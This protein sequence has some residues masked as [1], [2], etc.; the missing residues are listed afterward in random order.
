M[1][2]N[3]KA[4]LEIG[5]NTIVI[6][7]IAM[8]LLGLGIIFVKNLFG[9]I[10]PIT[11]KI[12]PPDLQTPPSASTPLIMDVQTFSLKT[13]DSYELDLGIYNADQ[14]DEAFSV[15]VGN[16]EVPPTATVQTQVPQ[17]RVLPQLIKSGEAGY[18]TTYIIAQYN[19]GG[20]A[21]KNME[22]GDFICNLEVRKYPDVTTAQNAK[23][24]GGTVVTSLQF[25]MTV[26]Q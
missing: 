13:G 21:L 26:D 3:K 11:Q 12:K 5:I 17:I 10:N 2:R 15:D 23:G 22:T 20:A 18:Y 19:T 8:M 24:T 9:Q 4:S 14:T 16:C 25:T 7:V 1:R 6:M